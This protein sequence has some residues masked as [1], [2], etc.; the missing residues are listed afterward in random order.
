MYSKGNK[1]SLRFVSLAVLNTTAQ[2]RMIDSY[3]RSFGASI[4]LSE[5]AA[6]LS[7]CARTVL[8]QVYRALKINKAGYLREVTSE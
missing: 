2:I 3:H 5:A 6:A 4:T 8:A 7:L 1:P